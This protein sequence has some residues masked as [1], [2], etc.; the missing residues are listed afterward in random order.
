MTGD[1]VD[2]GKL[3]QQISA[4]HPSGE[5]CGYDATFIDLERK[6]DG[7]PE[8]Q[9]GTVIQP[10]TPPDWR[11]VLRLC[12]DLFE[13][14]RDIRI[15]LY[16]CRALLGLHGLPGLA[17]GLEVFLGLVERHWP[18]LY[19][20]LDPDDDDP[21]E[22]VNI[23]AGLADTD[24]ML[25]PLRDTHLVSARAVGR[26]TLRQI[27]AAGAAN[28][29]EGTPDLALINAAFLECDVDEL[30]TTA[31]AAKRALDLARRIEAA[32][33][34]QVGVSNAPDLSA[35]VAVLS[36]ANTVLEPRLAARESGAGAD[37][38]GRAGAA[39]VTGAVP[40]AT[41]VT[42]A[43]QA[44]TVQM[45]GFGTLGSRADCVQALDKIAEYF[46][47]NEPSSP[48]PLLLLRAKR[49]IGMNFMDLLLDLTPDGVSQF[50]TI[51]GRRRDD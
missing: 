12:L 43:R 40:M 5:D 25:R 30:R 3:L 27:V 50:E 35:L 15:A 6:A 8:R 2:L 29:P 51:S 39:G 9:I 47:K 41:A 31:E 17:S 46:S 37:A 45:V 28:P 48:V 42:M 19:P 7:Q 49:L 44:H 16:L 18:T 14:T 33:T 1:I 21:I 38:D 11:E 23:V 13:R 36:D 32:V 26:F 20:Q 10:A 24:T 22:R 34:D 4:E